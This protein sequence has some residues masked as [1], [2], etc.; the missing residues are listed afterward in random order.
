MSRYK[1]H[2][3]FLEDTK[4][5]QHILQSLFIT[6]I[7]SISLQSE[8]MYDISYSDIRRYLYKLEIVIVHNIY[9]YSSLHVFQTHLWVIWCCEPFLDT[10]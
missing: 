2:F 10:N 5:D 1:L 3:P 7:K 8:K 6:F 9:M 4:F